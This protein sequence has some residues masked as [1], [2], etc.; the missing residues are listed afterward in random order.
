M[1]TMY[2]KDQWRSL[3]RVGR[4]PTGYRMKKSRLIV[5]PQYRGL[6]TDILYQYYVK[7]MKPEHIGVIVRHYRR[8][9]AG[10]DRF[11]KRRIERII[12]G[13]G[14]YLG[15][16]KIKGV[17]HE[18]QYIKEPLINKRYLKTTTLSDSEI[19]KF[20]KALVS[21]GFPRM[22]EHLMRESKEDHKK[23]PTTSK[24]GSPVEARR[25]SSTHKKSR[26]SAHT[27]DLFSSLSRGCYN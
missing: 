21:A 11:E 18:V 27:V 23:D 22:K 16:I 5:D 3:I 8:T 6:V 2:T 15:F 9:Y 4:P 25:S 19:S 24:S 10:S 17:Y 20:E 26:K 14:I 13:T 1:M 12:R 7:G